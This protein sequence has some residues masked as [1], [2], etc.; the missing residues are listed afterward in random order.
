VLFVVGVWRS[1]TSL[2]QALLNQHPQVGLAYEAELPLLKALFWGGQAR[3][4]WAA[5]W[6]FWNSAPSRHRV[7]LGL[8]GD[9]RTVTEAV[10]SQ[11]A[12]QKGAA[13]WGEKSPNYW[14]CLDEISRTFPDAKFVVVSRNPVS[15][16]RSVL[17]AAE[18]Q[19][20]FA[21]RGMGLRALL[22]CRQLK[23]QRDLLVRRG[24]AVCD[25][26]YEE[27]VREPERVLRSV[28]GFLAIEFDPRMTSLENADRASFYDGP[29]HAMV[30]GDRIVAAPAGRDTLPADF[31]A[32]IEAYIAL[33]RE[34]YGDWP[35][36]PQDAPPNAV[37]PGFF[38][39]ITDS[40]RLRIL[41]RFDRMVAV[42]YCWA[43][44]SWLS[45]YRSRKRRRANGLAPC[46]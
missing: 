16:C 3:K 1:G 13:I 29:H 5:R 41:R 7:T 25:V 2:L 26:Q 21:H 28:C 6:E 14:D 11:Y 35:L 27:L 9:L 44:L 12:A 42:I 38:E 10:Y 40:I 19:D 46:A 32:K 45:A 30:Q 34:Q 37:K 20:Y 39:R 24:V 33:W 43:P 8:G 31:K 36:Y 23:K 22:A 4:G 15:V 17:Q 18:T